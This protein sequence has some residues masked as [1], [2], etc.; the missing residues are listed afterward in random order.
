MP[1]YS[2]EHKVPRYVAPHVFVLSKHLQTS[3][4]LPYNNLWSKT[5]SPGLSSQPLIIWLGR[6]A[7]KFYSPTT[8]LCWGD[9]GLLFKGRCRWTFQR[10]A[11]FPPLL[12][13]QSLK[14]LVRQWGNDR[15]QAKWAGLSTCQQTKVWF[16]F[17]RGNFVCRIRQLNRNELGRLIH[18]M[19]GHNFL[20]RHRR[21]LAGEGSNFCHL[22]RSVV[23]D[24]LHLW[25]ACQ[26]NKF[27]GDGGFY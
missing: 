6:L 20:L 15:W 8:K 17:F 13:K 24:A 4:N 11:L 18:F 16:P 2:N 10:S 9:I 21:K 23:E 22:C 7:I 26:A 19:T 1:S 14:H 12:S 5:S 3:P 27:L 25:M